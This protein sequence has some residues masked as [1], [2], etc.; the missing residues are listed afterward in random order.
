MS[1]E[2]VPLE[3]QI[4]KLV[5]SIESIDQQLQVPSLMA[6]AKGL[7]KEELGA[8]MNRARDARQHRLGE[9]VALRFA[10]HQQENERT[11]KLRQQAYRIEALERQVAALEDTKR[12]LVEA[13]A[14]VQRM[15]TAMASGPNAE[16]PPMPS[17]WK[18]KS[19][20]GYPMTDELIFSYYARLMVQVALVSNGARMDG[21]E[22]KLF[23]HSYT[24]KHQ[25]LVGEWENFLN[26]EIQRKR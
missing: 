11:R 23:L 18:E 19:P 15:A 22:R 25:K 5:L 21:R 20:T 13:Q 9:L 2:S 3:V 17:E 10:L 4:E 7:S 12:Q 8:W 14:H 24:M 6:S 1:D 16:P 26:T